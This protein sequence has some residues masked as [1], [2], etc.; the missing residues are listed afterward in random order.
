LFKALVARWF[1]GRNLLANEGDI[2]DVGSI[3]RSGRSPGEGND[4]PLQY[5]CLENPTDRGAWSATGHGVAKG[6]TRLS[7]AH[8]TAAV[9]RGVAALASNTHAKA[10]SSDQL[11]ASGQRQGNLI[12]L[13]FPSGF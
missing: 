11:R 12:F 13:K 6:R 8:S 4:N 5:S 1:T 2:R 10:F 7:P 9:V 3:P